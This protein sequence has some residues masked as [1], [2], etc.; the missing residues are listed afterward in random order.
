MILRFFRSVQ[1]LALVLLISSIKTRAS[2]AQLLSAYEQAYGRWDIQLSKNI[3][4]ARRRWHVQTLTNEP[5]AGEGND[6]RRIDGGRNEEGDGDL[7]LLF[8]DM[9]MERR[10]TLDD[11]SDVQHRHR[12]ERTPTSTKSV[13]SV[14]CVLNLEKNGKFSLSLV[15]GADGDY[16]RNE[17]GAPDA[18][19]HEGHSDD[20]TPSPHCR[21]ATIKHRPLR[22]EWYL[23]PNPYCVTDRHYDEL[24]LVSETRMRR[25]SD[26][27]ERAR[28]EMRCQVWGRYGAGAIR[29]KIGLK[30]GRIRGRMNHGTIVIVR[31]GEDDGIGSEK[32]G[33]KIPITR[34]VVGTFAG[35]AIVDSESSGGDH[36]SLDI[37]DEL[38][39]DD[40]EHNYALDLGDDFDEIV[41]LEK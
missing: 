41:E 4:C 34:E 13:R 30:H 18:K 5:A 25:R 27:I 20:S 32:R 28:V 24:L 38:P 16:D 39:D 26:V 36:G 23:T 3:F 9:P 12:N 11:E 7:Q 19:G 6:R 33:K 10:G 14:S 15:E 2:N 21:R 40:E 37:E 17:K 35:R 29:R 31:E 1:F 22:G 8:P